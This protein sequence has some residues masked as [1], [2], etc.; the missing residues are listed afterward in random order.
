MRYDELLFNRINE[1]WTKLPAG[2]MLSLLR[3]KMHTALP[4]AIGESDVKKKPLNI[5]LGIDPTG[6]DIHIGHLCPVFILNIFLKCGHNVDFVIGDFTAKIGD[7][8]GRNT[9]RAPITDEQITKNFATYIK[10][11][12]GYINTQKLRVRKNSEWLA[13]LSSAELFGVLQKIKHSVATQREDFKKREDVSVAEIC[14]AALMGLDSVNLKTDIEI[15][16]LDQLLNFSQ[17]RLVQEIYR[18]KPE[19]AMTTHI[20]EGT[21]GDGRKMS[22]SYNNYISVT[23]SAE[24]KFGKFMSLPDLLLIKYYKA[25]AYLYEEEIP[26]L[27]KFIAAEPMEAKKQLAAYFVSIDGNDLNIGRA[28]REKFEKKFAKKELTAEDFFTIKAAAGINIIDALIDA[29]KFKS[30]GEIRRLLQ[31]GAIKNIDTD[32]KLGID[33]AVTKNIK[34]KAGK[35]NFFALEVK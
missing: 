22:K 34:I 35:L 4:A 17:C 18:Q 7:P 28:E 19:I 21:N 3:V 9:E 23:A 16:G 11:I 13:P 31:S 29:G 26:A 12:S 27:E 25:F 8:S 15:G 20:L 2:R 24:D 10:Q 6:A 30:K 1:D 33:Y 32:E 5:K 14:Y